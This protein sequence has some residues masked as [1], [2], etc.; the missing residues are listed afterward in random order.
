MNEVEKQIA[1][2][3]VPQA[4]K[5]AIRYGQLHKVAAQRIGVPKLTLQSVVQHLGTKLAQK[6]QR[7]RPV[8]EGL[9]ALQ[10][11]QR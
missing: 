6:Q 4:V 11:L 10:S 2:Q 3:F 5:D 7:W 9:L 8:A 1:A